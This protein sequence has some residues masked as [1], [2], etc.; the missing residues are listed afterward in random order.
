[1]SIRL[2]QAL[3]ARGVL[4][5]RDLDAALFESLA[6]GEPL[7][8]RL[9]ASG[10]VRPEQLDVATS[11]PGEITVSR[12][13]PDA[14][15]AAR[16]PEGLCQRLLVVP[17]RLDPLLGEALFAALDPSDP[18]VRAE[19]GHHLGA[20]VRLVRAAL[21]VLDEGLARLSAQPPAA[22]AVE[23][24]PL[25]ERPTRKTASLGLAPDTKPA[26]E[27]PIPLL[28]KPS[29]RPRAVV[30]P[31]AQGDDPV[32]PL[33]NSK[34]PPRLSEPPARPSD[35]PPAG[36]SSRPSGR[37]SY[38]F[39]FPRERAPQPL[40]VPAP[41]G[42]VLPPAPPVPTLGGAASPPEAPRAVDLPLPDPAPVFAALER[43][44]DAEEVV[45]AAL[46]GLHQVARRVAV[47]AVRQGVFEGRA[48][49]VAF[50]DPD[51]FRALRI[52]ATEPSAL[53]TALL[54]GLYFGPIPSTPALAPLLDAM[55]GASDGFAA[56]VARVGA[57]PAL[58]LAADELAHSAPGTQRLSE[59]AAKVGAAL[60]RLARERR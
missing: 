33:R 22:E 49:N 34:L 8:R 51:A 50:A 16:L 29:L 26:P 57:V 56:V 53:G 3:V 59:L 48:C 19:L 39:D 13:P 18:H 1:M 55:G 24:E 52:P 30:G 21:G 25:A 23:A 15:L 36:A 5:P 46:R 4:S 40:G 2:G 58:V 14:A 41:L 31:E 35:A 28:R 44:A 38:T 43:A 20:S 45:R 9:I 10:A 6:R 54:T 37:P 32:L 27:V 42:V 12:A 11:R 7:A 60:A 47:F 17:L